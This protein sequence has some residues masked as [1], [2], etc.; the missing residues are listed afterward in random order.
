ML[1]DYGVALGALAA[2]Q[3]VQP[4]SRQFK[5]LSPRPQ[6]F[7]REP[8]HRPWFHRRCAAPAPLA[9]VSLAQPP[10]PFPR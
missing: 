3:A 2:A 9:P 7:Y 5:H 4:P 10:P 6:W 1:L 8:R